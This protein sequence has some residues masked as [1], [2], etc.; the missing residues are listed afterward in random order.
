LVAAAFE[1]SSWSDD[2]LVHSMWAGLLAS[3]CTEDGHDETNLIFMNLMKNLIRDEVILLKYFCENAKV[4]RS[5][6]GWIGIEGE[7]VLSAETLLDILGYSDIHKIDLLLDHLREL[8]LLYQG[9][10]FQFNL[11]EALIRP[12]ALALNLYVRGQGYIGSAL[13]YFGCDK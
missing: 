4:V 9:S 10:G 12:S 3:S 11:A 1:Q 8:G 6:A 13:S 5:Q 2:D 7:I